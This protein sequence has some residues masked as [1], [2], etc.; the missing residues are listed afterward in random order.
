MEVRGAVWV[1][2]SLVVLGEIKGMV[3]VEVSGA[4]WVDVSLVVLGEV[5][6][7]V[8][9]DVSGLGEVGWIEIVKEFEI[10]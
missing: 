6:G 2:V 5:K 9:V 10:L 4:V 1:D 8:W 7:V 3:W